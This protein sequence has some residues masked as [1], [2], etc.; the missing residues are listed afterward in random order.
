MNTA[1]P[2]LASGVSVVRAV[3]VTKSSEDWSR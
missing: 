3:Q 2:A 1:C